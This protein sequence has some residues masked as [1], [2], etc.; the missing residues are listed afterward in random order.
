MGK[1]FLSHASDDKEFVRRL[2]MDLL[3]MGFDVWFDE[4][5]LQVGSKLSETIRTAISADGHFVL[6]LS[7][8]VISSDWVTKELEWALQQERLAQRDIILPI[9]VDDCDVPDAVTDRLYADFSVGYHGALHR[10]ASQLRRYPAVATDQGVQARSL[11]PLFSVGGTNLD[12]ARLGRTVRRLR[13]V[14]GSNYEVRPDDLRYA[15]EAE[16]DD[17]HRR[18]LGRL[19]N[20]HRDSYYTPA[21]A[22]DYRTHVESILAHEDTMRSRLASLITLLGFRGGDSARVGETAEW[23]WR[24]ARGYIVG[25][26]YNLQNPDDPATTAYGSEWWTPHIVAQAYGVPQDELTPVDVMSQSGDRYYYVLIP[27]ESE[28]AR[29][30]REWHNALREPLSQD[31]EI[32]FKWAIPQ[33]MHYSTTFDDYSEISTFLVG[34]H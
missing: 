21:F 15:Y 24:L 11:M 33:A 31:P 29:L 20:I 14:V 5:Q 26:M 13:T 7:S 34:L 23:Y 27:S 18:M 1:L 12:G 8:S 30:L 25:S 2:A 3:D 9:K 22:S 32:L 28:I 6:V 16:Y 10:L 19:D 4:W 17:L